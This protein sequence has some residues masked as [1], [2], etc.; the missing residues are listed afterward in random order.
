MLLRIALR[1]KPVKLTALITAAA[2]A[3][4]PMTAL[5]EDSRGPSSVRDT[6]TEQSEGKRAGIIACQGGTP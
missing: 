5:A 3:F 1:K 2:L 4:A 6:E